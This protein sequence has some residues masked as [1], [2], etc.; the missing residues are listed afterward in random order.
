[1]CCKPC[2]SASQIDLIDLGNHRHPDSRY[3]LVYRD[4]FTKYTVLRALPDKRASGVAQQVIQPCMQQP[5]PNATQGPTTTIAYP[6]LPH[7]ACQLLDIWVTL[8]AP[9]RL[10]SDNGKEFSGTVKLVCL[11]WGVE[12][13]HGIPYSPQTQGGVERTVSVPPLL[14]PLACMSLP[15]TRSCKPS[16]PSVGVL[17]VRMV[18]DAL[19]STYVDGTTWPVLLGRVQHSINNTP[20]RVL[21]NMTPHQAVF[22]STNAMLLHATPVEYERVVQAVLAGVQNTA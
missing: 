10:H 6:A 18:K 7:P 17:Q 1:M 13:V 5:E 20:T 12:Q 22:G 8:G 4:H 3:V 14:L 21:K 19:S 16:S 2:A 9:S 11:L 15:P